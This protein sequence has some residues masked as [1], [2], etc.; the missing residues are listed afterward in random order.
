MSFFDSSPPPPP[1]RGDI[2]QR[3]RRRQ[4]T[5]K[6]GLIAIIFVAVIAVIGGCAVARGTQDTVTFKVTDKSTKLSCDSDH[7]C[8]DTYLVFT[9]HGVYKDT[10]SLAFFKYNSSD[11]YGQLEIGRSYTCKVSGWRM[12]LFSSYRNIISCERA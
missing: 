8:K 3:A 11:I 9:D 4:N 12:P 7:N 2:R 5:A 1:R 6:V 10:D